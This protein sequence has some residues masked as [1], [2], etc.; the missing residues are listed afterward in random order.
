MLSETSDLFNPGGLFPT[1]LVVQNHAMKHVLVV[2]GGH[3]SSL[4]RVYGPLLTAD[5]KAHMH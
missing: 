3:Q 1:V 5:E 2:V 4:V